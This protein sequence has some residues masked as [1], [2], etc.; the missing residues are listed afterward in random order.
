MLLSN[1]AIKHR[2][3]RLSASVDEA[4]E[5]VGMATQPGKSI[6]SI[7]CDVVGLGG[8]AVDVESAC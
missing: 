6:V 2:L 3:L 5:L 4:A 1:A 7:S 8:E